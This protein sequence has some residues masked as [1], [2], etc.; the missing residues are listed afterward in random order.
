MIFVE[1]LLILLM[2]RVMLINSSNHF[3]SPFSKDFDEINLNESFVSCS[4]DFEIF[5]LNSST[6]NF[7]F[8]YSIISANKFNDGPHQAQTQTSTFDLNDPFKLDTQTGNLYINIKLTKNNYFILKLTAS[9][10]TSLISE[11]ILIVKI[12]E[13]LVK[14]CTSQTS[15]IEYARSPN[16]NKIKL[17][18]ADS[19]DSYD[20]SKLFRSNDDVA[21][22]KT[23]NSK[24][25]EIYLNE[26]L[27]VG[28][29][30]CY[31]L[32]RSNLDLKLNG[33]NSD[34]FRVEK[35]H[36]GSTSLLTFN[37]PT[38]ANF[39]YPVINLYTMKLEKDLD[40]EVESIHR[41]EIVL[42]NET[43]PCIE[44]CKLN[45]FV[46]DVND[47]EPKFEPNVYK[48]ELNENNPTNIS[49][50]KVRAFDRDLNENG[51]IEY[52]LLDNSLVSF[53]SSDGAETGKRN[54][55]NF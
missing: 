2:S 11:A 9:N 3:P 41:L 27:L 49:L 14:S 21:Y 7:N 43:E 1:S 54:L 15:Q 44:T 5:R 32:V 53:N 20:F 8:K 39:I 18:F 25:E 47:N 22:K 33:I 42:F 37:G 35:V 10:Q 31:I 50:G 40:R 24:P 12:D 28:S 16:T 45:I 52:F 4:S 26:D 29:F 13:K 46:N 6:H 17:L 19:L 55:Y 36:F 38:E 30:I 23:S 48:F 34:I 51:T